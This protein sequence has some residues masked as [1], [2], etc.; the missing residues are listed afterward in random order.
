MGFE[1]V[2]TFW[3]PAMFESLVKL[4]GSQLQL[5]SR[6]PSI[7][8]LCPPTDKTVDFFFD[9]DEQLFHGA[10][11]VNRGTGQ[12]KDTAPFFSAVEYSTSNF[13]S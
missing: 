9:V 5:H 1:T 3:H 10:S 7:W 4:R 2:N 6:P 12:S 11:R 8:R 13:A